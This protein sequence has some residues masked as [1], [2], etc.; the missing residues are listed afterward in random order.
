[1]TH[2]IMIYFSPSLYHPT[3]TVCR[4]NVLTVTLVIPQRPILSEEKPFTSTYH[5][6]TVEYIT[7]NA[8]ATHSTS[9]FY[10]YYCHYYYYYITVTISTSNLKYSTTSTNTTSDNTII[11]TPTAAISY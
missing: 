2:F 5:T 7:T 6:T 1:M 3:L 4:P 8:N 9:S 10:Y 11:A